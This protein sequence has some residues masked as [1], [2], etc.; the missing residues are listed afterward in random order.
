M[1]YKTTTAQRRSAKTWADKN[2]D[3]V[4]AYA[5]EW[6]RRNRERT[7]TYTR[8]RARKL[9]AFATRWKLAAGCANCGFSKHPAALDF[10]HVGE[11]KFTVGNAPSLRRLVQEIAKCVVRCANCHRIATHERAAK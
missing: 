4:R 5:R 8:V 9:R 1:K 6:Q 11:K 7:R 2:R 3:Y 10:D